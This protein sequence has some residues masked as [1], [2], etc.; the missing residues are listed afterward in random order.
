M[1]WI[2]RSKKISTRLLLWYER[3]SG[4][5]QSV[6]DS[7]KAWKIFWTSNFIM[8]LTDKGLITQTKSTKIRSINAAGTCYTQWHIQFFAL[9]FEKN[10][11]LPRDRNRRTNERESEDS[12]FINHIQ[13]FE[14]SWIKIKG[15][16]HFLQTTAL[17]YYFGKNIPHTFL[18]NWVVN[19]FFMIHF[20]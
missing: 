11:I 17:R 2:G 19:F 3:L 1:E 7:L 8:K 15:N 6:P 4:I 18:G 12:Q 5:S 16:K 14:A 13:F 9:L 10:K 20:T